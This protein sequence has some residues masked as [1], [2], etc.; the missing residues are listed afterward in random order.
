MCIT[1]QVNVISNV[2]SG[3]LEKNLND[4]WG[5]DLVTFLEVVKSSGQRL[6]T[7]RFTNF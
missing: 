4:V 5:Y 2:S 7:F 1:R 3:A 6:A